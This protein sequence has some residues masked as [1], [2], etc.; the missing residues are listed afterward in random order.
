MA[1]G[2]EQPQRGLGF[3][4]CRTARVLFDLF[5]YARHGTAL[6][7]RLRG[8]VQALRGPDQVQH[9]DSMFLF[10]IMSS[11]KE[12]VSRFLLLVQMKRF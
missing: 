9:L 1:L 11:L 7:S 10:K 12:K 5:L 8:R 4:V 2:R 6:H 3:C